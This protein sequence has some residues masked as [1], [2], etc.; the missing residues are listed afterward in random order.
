MKTTLRLIKEAIFSRVIGDA[1]I[2]AKLARPPL[3]SYI[4][5]PTKFGN[6]K[7]VIQYLGQFELRSPSKEEYRI[8]M[9]VVSY[10]HDLNDEVVYHLERLFHAR[11]RTH[12]KILNLSDGNRAYIRRETVTDVPAEDSQLFVKNVEFRVL[13]GQPLDS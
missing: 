7:A 13:C 11:G 6:Q 2:M 3:V 8:F 5:D 4:P 10:S 9:N 12:W 1:T